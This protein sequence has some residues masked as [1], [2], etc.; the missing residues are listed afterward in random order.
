[1]HPLVLLLAA[2]VHTV[3]DE[4]AVLRSAC[5]PSEPVVATVRRGDPVEVR[6]AFNGD[7]GPC[8]KVSVS[9]GGK[10]YEGYLPTAAVTAAEEFEI[11]RR[12]A[13]HLDRSEPLTP[14]M[15]SLA[16]T[17]K[18]AR[19]SG[20][21]A[22][23]AYQLIEDGQPE[24]A[25]AVL[26][27]FMKA[28]RRDAGILALA[29][30]AAYKADQ[31]RRAMGY[32]KESLDLAPSPNVERLYR[33]AEREAAS[34]QSSEKLIGARFHL[35]YDPA[36]V[37]PE[38]AR[39]I[40]PMLDSE[41]ARISEHLGCRA[42]E[43][44]GV[45]VQTRQA[46]LKTTGAAEWSGGRYDGRIHVAVPDG[47]A[48]S[49]ETRQALVHEVVHACL[50]RLGSWPA[51]LH[52]GLA[53][54]ISGETL[55]PARREEVR[56]MARGGTLPSLAKLGATWSRMSAQHATTAYAAALVAA[57]ILYDVHG[58]WGVRNLMQNPGSLERIAADL[59]RRLRE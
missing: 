48:N 4:Q 54:K 53:Q 32:W 35:R 1:M 26:E 6:F 34:D 36:E 28:N 52:E 11:A 58:A 5:G 56:K 21:P 20:D 37:K 41:F 17:A 3:R 10:T 16:A 50:T 44:I 25:L 8:Y 40:L 49:G 46:Y 39:S 24:T 30:L 45:I 59:D 2:T 29:G 9:S 19:S 42:E 51:W 27:Q 31:V 57:D 15:T 18:A 23:K 14:E 43:R 33:Q 7:S 38:Q 47:N 22:P 13:A 12:A 55:P